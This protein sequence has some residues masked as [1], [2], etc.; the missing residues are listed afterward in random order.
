MNR[1]L[2]RPREKRRPCVRRAGRADLDWARGRRA[3]VRVDPRGRRAH[4]ADGRGRRARHVQPS[5]RRVLRREDW[6]PFTPLAGVAAGAGR[7]RDPQQSRSARTRR[8]A[9]STATTCR[10]PTGSSSGRR[11]TATSSTARRSCSTSSCV[12]ARAKWGQE[13]SLV[14]LLPHGHEGQGPDHASARPERF[15]QLAADINHARGE[16]HDGGA[17]LPSAPPPGRPAPE[18]PAAARRSDAE[19]PAAASARRL[20]TARTG[21]R[22]LAAGH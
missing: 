14:L 10:R 1:K 15:L 17:V 3:G 13:P 22:A 5:P 12:S 19:E 4:P 18:R 11:S 6:P 9:S 21:R 8:S 7:M 20:L 16:L 2:E